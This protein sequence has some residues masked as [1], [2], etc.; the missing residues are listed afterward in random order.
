MYYFDTLT[1]AKN[2]AAAGLPVAQAEAHAQALRLVCEDLAE[3]HVATK[4]ELYE[5]RDDLKREI[6]EVRTELKQEINRLELKMAY[7]FNRSI[8]MIGS[9]ITV[10][11]VILGFLIK[12]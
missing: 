10:G 7:L 2:L 8:I 1:Y 5:V 4:G 11:T 3:N 9:F 6:S 12:I